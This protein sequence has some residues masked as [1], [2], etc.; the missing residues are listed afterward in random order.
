MPPDAGGKVY[1]LAVNPVAGSHY[2]SVFTPDQRNRMIEDVKWDGKWEFAFKTSGEKGP[3]SLP[4]RVWTAW[5]RIPFSDFGAKMP[6]DGEMWRFNVARKR[7]SQYMLWS[8]APGVTD[9]KALGEL[10]FSDTLT[11][12]VG[13]S[14]DT[15]HNTGCCGAVSR[16]SRPP[17][18]ENAIHE[19]PQVTSAQAT[20]DSMPIC[21]GH[22]DRPH[23]DLGD[24]LKHSW[25]TTQT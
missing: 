9:T 10:I 18:Q 6:A 14:G 21:I 11:R 2:D 7:T 1:R 22:I 5:F 20:R 8:D 16:P 17:K 12:P 25:A 4:G 19:L 15:A 24:L 13:G 3:W 23:E